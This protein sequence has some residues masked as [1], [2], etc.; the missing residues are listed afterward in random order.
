MNSLPLP[1]LDRSVF[2]RYAGLSLPRHVAYPMPTW[3]KSLNPGQVRTLRHATLEPKQRRA[4]S[5]YL[6]IPFC[7]KSCR[8]CACNRTILGRH[9]DRT[10][11]RV[12]RYLDALCSEIDA[13][14][15][16]LGHGVAVEQIH[17]GGGTPTYLNVE[18]IARL[19]EATRRAF[20]ISDDAECS[21]EVDPRVTTLEQL[22]TLAGLGFNRVSMG[23]QDF[24]PEVQ[25]HVQ[26]VQPLE[27]VR[28]LTQAARDEGFESVNYDLIYGLPKQTTASVRDTVEHVIQLRP[29]RI[30]FYH[31]AQIPDRVAH[32]R[33]LDHTALPDSDA[34][35]AMFLDA[36]QRFT[37]AGYYFI[38]LDHFALPD[39]RLAVAAREGGLQRSFQGMT[40][41]S[42]LDLIGMGCSAISTYPGVAY[43][44]NERDPWAYAEAIEA[45]HDPAIR[46]LSLSDD[47]AVR[48][49]MLLEL[50]G[51]A[52]LDRT[53]LARTLG[54]AVHGCF[55]AA[56]PALAVLQ[57][58]G[59]IER[60][61]CGGLELT[62]PLGRVLM[63]N[64]AA[65]FDA[66]LG[67]EAPWTG[68]QTAFSASA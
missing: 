30:A 6:H 45:R 35:L 13:R 15:R 58:D 26:R 1:T 33:G 40:T 54:D 38:G 61:P 3:W 21:I 9:N 43:V 23:V 55:D 57:S 67:K 36:W 53:A 20:T 5:L 66:Y 59:L 18:Q 29:D 56:E 39:E 46:G 27:T 22:S 8:F 50:Y 32:Q 17:W 31:Y 49:A 25:A 14:G 41:G 48:Q 28:D 68:M 7:A 16:T 64:V 52:R 63:R 51:Q 12:N 47:D 19:H 11:A 24:D 34:K 4:L 44:Q 60:T 42:Q 2:D 37:G 62:F 65:A 10:D